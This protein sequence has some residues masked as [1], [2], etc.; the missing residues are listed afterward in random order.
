MDS[1]LVQSQVA[2]ALRNLSLSD[3][4]AEQIAVS[5]GIEALVNAAAEH[6][7]NSKVQA[8]V[9]GALRNL[10]VNDEIAE[11]I[12]TAGGI[13]LNPNPN[14]SPNPN[15]N[16]NP[17]QAG[18]IDALILASSEHPGN[19]DVQ[20]EVAGALWGLSVNDDIEEAIAGANGIKVPTPN[21]TPNHNPT[22]NL[23]QGA[24]RGGEAPPLGP[25]VYHP[26]PRCLSPHPGA[27]RGGEAPLRQRQGAGARGGRAAQAQR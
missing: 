2:G 4:V 8:G 10:S 7:G 22:P 1:S 13:D 20:A 9:A 12:A 6:R 21:L 3:E 17:K 18:G 24:G 16:P 11:E 14:P 15:P 5:G 19:S 27:G 26:M 23:N 25:A